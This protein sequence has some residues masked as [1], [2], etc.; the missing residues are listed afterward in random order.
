MPYDF[1]YMQNRKTNKQNRNR[2]IDTENKQMVAKGKGMKGMV[3]KI[4]EIFLIK[5]KILICSIKYTLSDTLGVYM[6]VFAHSFI[7]SLI[8][9]RRISFSLL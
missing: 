1:T 4:K 2:P 6:C 9:L 8:Y 7:Q 5:N 3:G